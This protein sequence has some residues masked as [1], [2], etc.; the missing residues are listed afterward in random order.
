MLQALPTLDSLPYHEV[1]NL[2]EYKNAIE[3]V[4]DIKARTD[5]FYAHPELFDNTIVDQIR[6]LHKAA[7]HIA[8]KRQR[9]YRQ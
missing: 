1:I 7:M 3:R 6:T 8:K 5:L 9:H 2:L 4:N